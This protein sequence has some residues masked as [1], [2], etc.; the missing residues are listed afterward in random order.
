MY[1]DTWLSL[2]IFLLWLAIV[3]ITNRRDARQISHDVE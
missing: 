1:D 2:T 3:I